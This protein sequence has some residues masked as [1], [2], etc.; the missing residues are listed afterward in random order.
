MI[1]VLNE[2]ND[3]DED[4]EILNHLNMFHIKQGLIDIVVMY[5][6]DLLFIS[7]GLN[8]LLNGLDSILINRTLFLLPLLNFY[9]LIIIQSCLFLISSK[10]INLYLNKIKQLLTK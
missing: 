4:Y 1:L 9:K 7:Y 3:L 5:I 8:M 2:I 10:L 6:Y